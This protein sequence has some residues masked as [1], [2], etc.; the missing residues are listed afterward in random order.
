MVI[1]QRYEG[2]TTTGDL[3]R[4]ELEYKDRFRIRPITH[5]YIFD[6]IGKSFRRLGSIEYGAV[7]FRVFSLFGPMS[8]I[9]G[10]ALFG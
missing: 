7:G 8:L 5:S 1:G 3:S 4:L 6:L 10:Y 9:Q 2:N